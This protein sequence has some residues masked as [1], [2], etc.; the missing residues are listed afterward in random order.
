[1]LLAHDRERLLAAEP[2]QRV[3]RDHEV[4]AGSVELAA[5]RLGGV[6]PPSLDVVTGARER[7]LD[8]S[9]IVIGVFN[10]QKP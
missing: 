9:R 1:M 7:Q 2:R 10:L 8:Q 4:P 3:V 6:Y 5:Q